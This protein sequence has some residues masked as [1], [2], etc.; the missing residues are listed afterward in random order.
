MEEKIDWKNNYHM[1]ANEWGKEYFKNI[2][3]GISASEMEKRDCFRQINEAIMK[4][5][6]GFL[7][8]LSKDVFVKYY[9]ESL[10]LFKDYYDSLAY[11]YRVHNKHNDLKYDRYTMLMIYAPI[12]SS[13]SLEKLYYYMRNFNVN[14]Q[15][16]NILVSYYK[17]ELSDDKN[18]SD[19]MSLVIELVD[20]LIEK[21]L[22]VSDLLKKYG[23]KRSYFDSCLKRLE[24]YDFD[25]YQKAR[26]IISHPSFTSWRDK[27]NMTNNDWSSK[28]FSSLVGG[29]R[30]SEAKKK[31]CLEK[32]NDA[33]RSN[34]DGK[35]VQ[36][37][38]EI[39][40]NAYPES[41]DMLKEYYDSLIYAH[42]KESNSQYM[43]FNQYD[44]S[45]NK[46][47]E[48]VLIKDR[49]AMLMV[50]AP[51]LS[52]LPV[53]RLAE[54]AKMFGL[55]L[56]NISNIITKYKRSFSDVVQDKDS[57]TNNKRY[58]LNIIRQIV[59]DVLVNG[60]TK[61][62]LEGKYKLGS[63]TFD[64][65][66][67]QLEE[68]DL[69][70]YRQV[71]DKLKSNSNNYIFTMKKIMPI[72]FD[73][74]INGIDIDGEK[75]SFTMLDYYCL[76]NKNVQE[77]TDYI[78]SNQLDDEL[79]PMRSRVL[80]FFDT[81]KNVGPYESAERFAARDISI[82]HKDNKVN[83]DLDVSL[84]IVNYLKENNIPINYKIVYTAA[85]RYARGEDI[86]PLVTMKEKEID[87][88][89]DDLH[90]GR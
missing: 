6:H 22:N 40:L 66:M 43:E 75:V 46:K 31:L 41:L 67:K 81:F 68:F 21:N 27:Y 61:K 77:I 29:V 79:R 62:A 82:I 13:L 16:M 71:M 1:F 52:T 26:D 5:N 69:D 39:I 42:K 53:E 38:K 65:Y 88:F 12:F 32:I 57:L 72:L 90:R 24:S 51:Y 10:D 17:K 19:D 20:E 74:I 15:D 4:N 23:I 8:E 36:L 86:L 60:Y 89:V 14:F 48:D 59:K 83:F 34:K 18:N 2:V 37:D 25:R 85:R 33:I 54:Y 78:R 9:P 35:V 70:S 87:N 45:L 7:T 64:T 3:G 76:T 58:D 44:L 49:N 11:A 84:K 50:Y 55:K 30:V 73:Y 28:Y 63:S 47:W 80:K 56:N